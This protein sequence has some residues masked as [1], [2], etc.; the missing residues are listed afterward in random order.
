MAVQR[1]SPVFPRTPE[2]PGAAQTPPKKLLTD[3]FG[4]VGWDG[5]GS[6]C[7]APAW[8]QDSLPRSDTDRHIPGTQTKITSLSYFP[9]CAEVAKKAVSCFVAVFESDR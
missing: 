9:F 3:R 1:D 7:S 4:G 2:A 5:K 6:T 8:K